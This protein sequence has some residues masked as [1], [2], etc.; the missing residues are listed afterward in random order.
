M[1]LPDTMLKF[2]ITYRYRKGNCNIY[3]F[4][5]ENSITRQAAFK[6]DDCYFQVRFKLHSEK[7]FCPMPEAQRVNA[8]DEDYLS[9]QLL[10]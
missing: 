7:G 4:T 9:N 2:D 6:D 8:K 5:L 1:Q 3:T 10:Y